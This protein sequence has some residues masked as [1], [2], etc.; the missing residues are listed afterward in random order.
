MEHITL[1][2]LK[3]KQ[4]HLDGLS[5]TYL[6]PPPKMDYVFFSSPLFYRSFQKN[7]HNFYIKI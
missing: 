2:K 1:G 7:L 4:K 5:P 6:N 3:T